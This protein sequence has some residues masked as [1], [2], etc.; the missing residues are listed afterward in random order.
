[1][2]L[3]RAYLLR[4]LPEPGNP[5]PYAGSRDIAIMRERSGAS[6]LVLFLII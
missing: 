5:D 6:L 2:V 3:H 4:K 1:M